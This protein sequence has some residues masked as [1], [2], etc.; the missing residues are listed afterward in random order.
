MA[1]G[2]T[3]RQFH[4]QQVHYLRKTITFADAGVAKTVGVLPAGS[5]IL[6][7]CSGVNVSTAFNSSGTD[8]IDVGTTGTADLYATDLAGQTVGFA[9]LDEAVSAYVAAETTITATYAQSV[10]D[11]TAGV[12]QVVIAYIPNNDG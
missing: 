5:L 1:A 7:P 8:L 4:T 6:K 9:A 10:A 11:A 3:A 2:S 12:A